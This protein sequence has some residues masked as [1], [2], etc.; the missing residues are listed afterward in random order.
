MV[1]SRSFVPS[2]LALLEGRRFAPQDDRREERGYRR[3]YTGVSPFTDC[4]SVVPL[5]TPE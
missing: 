5:M 2:S 3:S 4:V 1:D